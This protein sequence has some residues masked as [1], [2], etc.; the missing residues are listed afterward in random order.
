MND[1][2][3]NFQIKQ[4][5]ILRVEKSQNTK[6]ILVLSNATF[7]YLLQKKNIFLHP[8]ELMYFN[9]LK[10]KKRQYS[11]L[12]GRYAAKIA[13]TELLN[14]TEYSCIE[15]SN[16]IFKHPVIN[17]KLSQ[18]VQVSISHSL[19]IGA[20]LAFSELHPMAI[21]VEYIDF[22]KQLDSMVKISSHEESAIKK[23]KVHDTV[24]LTLIWSAKEALSKSLKTGLAANQ[25]IFEIETIREC[26]LNLEITFKNFYQYKVLSWIYNDYVYSIS[27]PINSDFDMKVIFDNEKTN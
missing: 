19:Y 21:D 24:I 18:P 26:E 25:K 17:E 27:L 4:L 20:A 9:T 15:I 11:F 12:I 1:I 16:G 7:S 10:N 8:N 23:T 5:N 22:S 3:T 6:A 14:E 13:V 2:S